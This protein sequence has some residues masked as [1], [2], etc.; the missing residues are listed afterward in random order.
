MKIAY[1]PAMFA[2]VAMATAFTG[3]EK[4]GGDDSNKSGTGVTIDGITW[5]TSNVGESG[6]FVA[7]FEDSGELYDF[8]TAQTVCPVGWRTPT[9]EEFDKLVTSGYEWITINNVSGLQF[10]SGDNTVFFPAAGFR[11]KPYDEEIFYN[12]GQ[13][14]RYWSSVAYTDTHGGSMGFNP[15]PEGYEGIFISV[16][17]KTDAFQPLKENKFS[18]RCVKE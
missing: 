8:D 16:T 2:M 4:G 1:L 9:I 5:A 10:G 3:C 14:G 12:T 17:H 11:S 18:V 15:R 13:D 7:K 6:K